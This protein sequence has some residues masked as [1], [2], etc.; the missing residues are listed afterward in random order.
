ML[1]TITFGHF[2][3][4]TQKVTITGN[5]DSYNSEGYDSSKNAVKI[6]YLLVSGI[7]AK[8]Y[9]TDELAQKYAEGKFKEYAS[10]LT[11]RQMIDMLSS[12]ELR[13]SQEMLHIFQQME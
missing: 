5:D 9:T 11:L 1:N 6:S 13:I 7:D 10:S 8:A 4:E 3:K 12:Q 2:F